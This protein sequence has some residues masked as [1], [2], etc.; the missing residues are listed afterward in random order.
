MSLAELR[1]ACSIRGMIGHT[2]KDPLDSTKAFTDTLDGATLLMSPEST[3]LVTGFQ[4]KPG[5]AWTRWMP[6]SVGNK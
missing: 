2:S 6:D 5:A 1:D 4:T 3:K